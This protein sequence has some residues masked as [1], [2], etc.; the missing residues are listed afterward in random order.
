MRVAVCGGK[1]FL[2]MHLI[3][4]VLFKVHRSTHIT[5]LL[6]GN[7]RGVDEIVNDWARRTGIPVRQIN[8]DWLAY[9]DEADAV[10]NQ[11]VI[12]ERPDVVVIF[13]GGK[14]TNDLMDKA[15]AIGHKHILHVD[16]SRDRRPARWL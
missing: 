10:R 16:P 7:C 1:D 2:A 3:S 5:E 13:P 14:R 4:A 12:D 15:I 9:G 11:M 8:S 6:I